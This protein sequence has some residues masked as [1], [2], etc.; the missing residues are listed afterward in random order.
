MHATLTFPLWGRTL[1]GWLPAH[2][3]IRWSWTDGTPRP[4]IRAMPPSTGRAACAISEGEDKGRWVIAAGPQPDGALPTLLFCENETNAPRLFG[5]ATTTP[6]PEDGINDHLLHGAA[7]VNPDTHGTRMSCWYRVHVGA[8]ETLELRLRFARM[9]GD[10][11]PDLGAT[12]ETAIRDREAEADEI[13]DEPHN[14]A[15]GWIGFDFEKAFGRPT[16]VM[17]DP[18]LQVLGSYSSGTMRFLGLGKKKWRKHVRF[19]VERFSAAMHPDEIVIG[20]GN[21]VKL[22]EMPPGCR[23]GDNPNAFLGGF[24]LWKRTDTTKRHR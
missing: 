4:L 13:A 19:M 23:L 20:G 3:V 6:Y 8:R 16:K 22:K 1:F 21:A 7:A 17:N 18:A 12:F 10:V 9:D 24:R 2:D 14:L 5:A 15:P 11:V